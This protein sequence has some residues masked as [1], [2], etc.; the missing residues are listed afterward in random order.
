MSLKF[1]D[2]PDKT[3]YVYCRVSTTNQSEEGLSLDVQK[4][5]GIKL[6]K[7][8]NLKPIVIQEQGSGIKPYLETRP[9]FN[10]LVD[11]IHD[12]YVENIWIDE[13]TRLTRNDTDQQFLHILMKQKEVN[14]FVGT[15]TTPKKWDWITDLVDTI[16]TKVNL[17]QIKTQVRKSIRS[18]RKLFEQG[19]WMKGKPPFG[20]DL[21]DKKLVINKEEGEILN[22]IFDWYDSGMSVYRIQKELF[23]KGYTKTTRTIRTWLSKKTYI[24]INTYTDL[25][26]ESPK[27]IDE[28]V[29]NS[30]QKKLNQKTVRTLTP[31]TDFLLRDIIKCPDGSNMSTLGKKKSRKN[32]LYVCRHRKRKYQKRI[33]NVDC[34]ISKS[35]RQELM[36]DYV[37]NSLVD[38]LSQSHQIK[39][40]TK[41]ELIGKKSGYTKRGINKKIKNIQKEILELEQNQMILDKKFYTNQME[42]KKYDILVETIEDK[43]REL[44]GVLTSLKMKFDI[45]RKDDEWIDWLSIH[46]NRMDEIRN[47][48]NFEEKRKTLIHYIHEILVLNYD[49]DT[50]Q[51]TISVKFRFPLFNDKHMWVYNKDG[52]YRRD[53]I[54]RRKY[55]IVEGEDE[56]N[57]LLTLH[58]E[59][60]RHII[61]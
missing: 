32:P 52:S 39:E 29:F 23:S 43:E 53:S 54:G 33:L 12:C 14:L 26:N 42:K 40:Q 18:Q 27:I 34:S 30:V 9:L 31:K 1:S 28:K 5:R 2:K 45:L 48:E 21:V 51:H 17:N 4:E 37:W 3:L 10:E 58:S 61:R 8:L 35:L 7:E 19:F 20:Y 41:K 46:F 24:G 56:K 47:I 22:K 60:T 59:H 55:E 11:G 49:E 6:S 25:T 44:I 57:T 16:I 50:K 15:S 38:V 36:D 13:E